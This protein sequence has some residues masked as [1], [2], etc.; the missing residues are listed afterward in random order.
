MTRR[1]H[2]VCYDIADPKRLSRVHRLV[3]REALALQYSVFAGAWTE[4]GLRRMIRALEEVIDARDDDVRI[5]PV[6]ERCNPVFY[7][8][9]ASKGVYF[10]T[11]LGLLRRFGGDAEQLGRWIEGRSDAERSKVGIDALKLWENGEID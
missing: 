9:R 3:R 7:G 5:Y 2:L 1:V 10:P 8:R 11:G 6:P 4:D